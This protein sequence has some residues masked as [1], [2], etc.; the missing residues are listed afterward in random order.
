MIQIVAC[1]KISGRY[2]LII[3]FVLDSDVSS[4]S[5]AVFDQ[6]KPLK[7]ITELSALDDNSSADTEC[8]GEPI[9]EET[10]VLDATEAKG[11]SE[12]YNYAEPFTLRLNYQGEASELIIL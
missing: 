4:Y 11:A 12:I 9:K 5:E 10:V 1:H 3:F 6:E 2:Q 8:P 7:S